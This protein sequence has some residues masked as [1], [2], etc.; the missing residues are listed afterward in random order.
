[1]STAKRR[2][3]IIIGG[4]GGQGILVMGHIL[5]KALVNKGCYVVNS[6]HYSAETRGG[7]SRS[8]LIVWLEEEEPDSILISKADYAIFMY[9]EQMVMYEGYVS[10]DA[11]VFIDSSFELSAPI[12]WTK[13]H[14]KPFTE[15][16]RRELGTERVANMVALGYFIGKTGLVDVEA[17][18]KVI[19]ETVRKD[20]VDINIKALTKG[21]ELSKQEA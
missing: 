15:V 5:G 8:D 13:A 6:E 9:P 2:I 21:Y 1:M 11:E 10:E 18:A 17:V 19:E 3:E 16:A 14:L 7:F 12:K 4:R 20:W